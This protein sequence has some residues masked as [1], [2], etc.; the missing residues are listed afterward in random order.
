L[1]SDAKAA[2]YSENKGLFVIRATGDS[3]S[4]VNKKG[5]KPKAFS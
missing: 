3:A 1:R 2:F 5:F 4:I